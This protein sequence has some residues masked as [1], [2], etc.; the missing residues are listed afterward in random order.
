MSLIE[1]IAVA[2]Y[3]VAIT[4]TIKKSQAVDKKENEDRV[5]KVPF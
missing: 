5:R 1:A 2:Y 4:N 3:G